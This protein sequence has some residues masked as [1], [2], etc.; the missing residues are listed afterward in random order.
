M[1]TSYQAL[2]NLKKAASYAKLAMHI[3]GPHSYK[4]GQGALLKVVYKFGNG[5]IKL[6][7]LKKTLRWKQDEVIRVAKKAAKNGYV[8]INKKKDKTKTTVTITELGAE[9][10]KKRLQAE[11]RAADEIVS[12]LSNVEVYKLWELT[13]KIIDTCKAMGIDYDM[14]R[15]HPEANMHTDEWHY[16]HRHEDRDAPVDKETEAKKPIAD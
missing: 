13:G 1:T 10:I 2:D 14:I 12:K 6:K 8:T 5:T 15:K 4:K 9:I 7:K 3:N 16:G 11:D